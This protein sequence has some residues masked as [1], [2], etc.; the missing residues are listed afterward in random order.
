MEYGI[1]F[2]AFVV[3]VVAGMLIL[4]GLSIVT[5]RVNDRQATECS[6]RG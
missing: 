2:L 5:A 1:P 4:I 6:R 3:G